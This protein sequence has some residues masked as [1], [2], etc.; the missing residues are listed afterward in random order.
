MPW[1]TVTR[2]YF[3]FFVDDVMLCVLQLPVGG[4]EGNRMSPPQPP[5]PSS[6]AL[7]QPFVFQRHPRF[8]QRKDR[9]YVYSRQNSAQPPSLENVPLVVIVFL[10]LLFC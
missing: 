9:I 6:A 4:A 7:D 2:P 5:S 8:P 3:L 1:V 10:F